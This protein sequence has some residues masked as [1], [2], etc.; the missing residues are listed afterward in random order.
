MTEKVLVTGASG[1]IASWVIKYLL[2][3]GYIVNVTVRDKNNLDKIQHLIDFQLKYPVQLNLYEADLLKKDS[4]KEAMKGCDYVI[5]TASP[6]II[7]GIK[8]AQKELIEPAL[9]GTRNVLDTVNETPEVKRVVLT[10]SVVS[11]YGD[12]LD[13]EDTKNNIFD[14]SIWNTTSSLTHQPYSYSKKLAEKEAWK[15]NS[16]QNRWDLI[17]INP[18]FVLGPSITHRIDSTSIDFMRN[19]LNGKLRTGVPK[20]SFGIVDVRSV[21]R[22]H[23]NAIKI[24]EAKGRYILVSETLSMKDIANILNKKYGDKYSIPKNELPNLVIYGVGPFIGF[25]WKYI[26]R[27]VGKPLKF[28]NSKSRKELSINYSK[29]EQT[30]LDHTEQLI[31]DGLI[32]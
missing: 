3:D 16:E 7:S 2:E 25:T 28:D 20:L 14:E 30:I 17:T 15:I 26:K 31:K 9:E 32:K 23:V 4:F 22:A 6:F 13:L 5:H 19:M 11:I 8:D 24:K 1:Y 21:A 18:G 29:A 27:N 12:A 10:S